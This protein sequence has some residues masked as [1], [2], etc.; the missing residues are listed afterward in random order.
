MKDKTKLVGGGVV[1]GLIIAAVLVIATGPDATTRSILMPSP[2]LAHAAKG[3]PL[4]SVAD[5]AERSLPSVVN[6]STTRKHEAAG[7]QFEMNPFFK[8]FFRHFGPRRPSPRMERSLGSGVIVSEDGIVVTNN[9]V[10]KNADRIRVALGKREFE[11]KVV[12]TDPRSDL[13]VLRLKGA[14]GLKPIRYGD[15]DR[16]RLGDTVLAIGNPFG[17]GQTVTMGIVSAK[18]RANVGIVD[19]EDFIQTDAAINP[20]NSGGALINMKG[21]LVG[22]NTAILSR[23]GGY[24]G[25][26]FAIPANMVRPII[27][28]LLKKGRVVR[29]WLGVAIQ[30][31][32]RDLKRA[33]K[34]PT[35]DGVLI[36]DVDRA[37]PARKAGLKRGD[38]LVRLN[39]KKVNST[40][41]LRNLVA[42]AGVGA[43]VSLDYYRGGKLRTVK[44]TLAELPARLG[45]DTGGG[46]PG[47]VAPAKALGL[48][49]APLDQRVRQRYNIP[50]RLKHGV[51]VTGV[52]P[53]GPTARAGLRPG[54]VILEA[55]RGKIGSVRRF[56][57]IL[58]AAKGDIL[59]LVYRQG[60]TLYMIVD[61]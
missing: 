45:G 30:D 42:S 61:R 13:A 41:R 7:S 2:S 24:Q 27:R 8:D 33:L 54:D 56:S 48:S 37:G 3:A 15:S 35:T 55:N 23:S 11:A 20:G 1:G 26:G 36:S 21:E 12:G 57:Q 32:N 14:R 53:R 43:R 18:G 34:L 31:V 60:S 6:I 52:D 59:F 47:K 5:V 49:V 16:L 4:K 46:Q 22:I 44:V 50:S 51:V 29:G 17:V 10:V 40:G 19:Y 25:I 9:H 38:L 28:S 58:R 39:G